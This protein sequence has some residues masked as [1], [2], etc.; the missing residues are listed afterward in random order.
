MISDEHLALLAYEAYGADEPEPGVFPWSRLPDYQKQAW[1]RA[2][3]AVAPAIRAAALEE[4]A[5]MV[6]THVF[7]IQSPGPTYALL[8]SPRAKGDLHHE[9]IATAIRAMIPAPPQ[10]A[11]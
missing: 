9:T 7:T 4:A 2:I 10:P 1:L 11:G 3:E 8:P 6:E 5:S